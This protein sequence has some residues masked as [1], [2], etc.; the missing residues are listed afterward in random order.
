[1]N[2]FKRSISCGN[3]EEFS[4]LVKIVNGSV[5][6]SPGTSVTSE[7]MIH[8]QEEKTFSFYNV[9]GVHLETLKYNDESRITLSVVPNDYIAYIDFREM[10]HNENDSLSQHL[11]RPYT[12]KSKKGNITELILTTFFENK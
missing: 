4:K 5:I 3:Q 12:I 2:S 7:E 10:N 11:R 8:N 9:Y 1:M 6:V